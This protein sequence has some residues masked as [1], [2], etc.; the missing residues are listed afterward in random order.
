VLG[1]VGFFGAWFIPLVGIVAGAIAIATS[2]KAAQTEKSGLITASLVVGIVAVV[3]GVISWALNILL[4][5]S[6][7]FFS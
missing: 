4:L 1:I 2:R 6:M 7:G 5:S 3:F